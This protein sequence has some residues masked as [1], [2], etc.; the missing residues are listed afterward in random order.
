MGKITNSKTVFQDIKSKLTLDEPEEI[1]AVALILMGNYYGVTFTDI[2][3]EKEVEFQDLSPILFRLNHDEPLQYILGESELYG[4]KFKVHPSVLIPRPE[5]ELL[6][7]EVLKIEIET[8]RILDVGTGSGCIAITLNLE[9]QNSK[10][11]SV[12]VSQLALET[13]KENSK[14]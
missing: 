14:K 1:H 10:V 7:R 9:I 3:A 6:I 4:R 5:T 11:Y 12:D 8:P 2:I 13:A